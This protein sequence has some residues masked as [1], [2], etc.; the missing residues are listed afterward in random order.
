[1]ITPDQ[2][3][4]TS[5]LVYEGCGLAMTYTIEGKPEFIFLSDE[6][7]MQGLL[8]GKRIQSFNLKARSVVTL[9]GFFYRFDEYVRLNLDKGLATNLLVDH[10]NNQTDKKS[11][12]YKTYTL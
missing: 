11:G 5:D 6:Q 9:H 8:R 4:I 7:I 3:S 12:N 1:M 2:I 10:I